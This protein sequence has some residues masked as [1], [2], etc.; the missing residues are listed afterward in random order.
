MQK[1]RQQKAEGGYTLVELLVSLIVGALLV[2]SVHTIYTNQLLI[3]Q[4]GRDSVLANAFVEGKM[5][6]LRSRGYLNVPVGTTDITAELPGEL[7]SPRNASQQVT[8]QAA[9][10]KKVVVTVNYN[11]HGKNQ[12]ST[13]TTYLGELG[14]GQY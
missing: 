11:L 13:Y 1:H 7:Q 2:G 12:S 8:A 3:S 10:V 5:E 9:S 4:Q 14:V 6:T